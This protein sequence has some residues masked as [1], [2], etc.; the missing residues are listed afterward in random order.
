ME[1]SEWDW[2]W[3][4]ILWD[5]Q[6]RIILYALAHT[7]ACVCADAVS[8][9]EGRRRSKSQQ[10]QEDKLAAASCKRVIRND[11]IS[12][13]YTYFLYILI[14]IWW[15]WGVLFRFFY[16]EKI[17][18]LNLVKMSF[19]LLYKNVW[20]DERALFLWVHGCM[21]ACMHACAKEL[22]WHFLLLLSTWGQRCMWS[23]PLLLRRNT[24]ETSGHMWQ[25][26]GPHVCVH[27]GTEHELDFGESL[28]LSHTMSR[29]EAFLRWVP[30][31]LSIMFN[32]AL[33]LLWWCVDSCSNTVCVFFKQLRC[34]LTYCKMQQLNISKRF[35]MP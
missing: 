17:S 3:K 2:D 12:I 13:I 11:V 30:H 21:H 15:V 33:I 26:W 8:W 18:F 7:C 32:A 23:L 20:F 1:P 6:A 35:Q 29:P 31:D 9:A 5:L 19:V 25:V 24:H 14:I 4:R 22:P 16:C 28:L 34:F 10:T 27:G